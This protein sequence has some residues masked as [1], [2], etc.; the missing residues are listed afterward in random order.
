M[1]IKSFYAMEVLW[2]S[3]YLSLSETLREFFKDELI[4]FGCLKVKVAMKLCE[5]ISDLAV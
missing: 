5:G 3:G 4:R 1:H 2:F